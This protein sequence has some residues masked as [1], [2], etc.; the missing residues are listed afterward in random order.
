MDPYN[1][2][3]GLWEMPKQGQLY[4]PMTLNGNWF[5]RRE[6]ANDLANY[7]IRKRLEAERDI[8]HRIWIFHESNRPYAEDG[9]RED[10]S[11]CFGDA[12]QL[13]CCG[14][15]PP[16][17]RSHTVE[18][19]ALAIDMHMSSVEESGYAQGYASNHNEPKGRSV[20]VVKRSDQ[21]RLTSQLEHLYDI[22]LKHRK[23]T[24][25]L[26]PLPTKK[27]LWTFQHADRNV[28]PVMEEYLM[29]CDLDKDFVHNVQKKNAY[30]RVRKISLPPW[31]MNEPREKEFRNDLEQEVADV[32]RADMRN[33]GERYTA[34]PR[35]CPEMK[36]LFSPYGPPTARAE[37]NPPKD[38]YQNLQTGPKHLR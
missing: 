29:T 20:F 37:R 23:Q 25:W 24:V 31:N 14:M 4:T 34:T 30:F 28:R 13:E 6:L 15:V 12:I 9:Y 16:T 32:G 18:T 8:D 10:G 7:D 11:I 26:H 5:E 35:P 3:A 33:Y 21:W 1:P 27:S 38:D 22:N 2:P 19:P 36:T 17:G